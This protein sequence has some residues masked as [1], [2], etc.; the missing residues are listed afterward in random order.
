MTVFNLQA[1]AKRPR[2]T[3]F[4]KK[5]SQGRRVGGRAFGSAIDLGE[6][7][8]S[9]IERMTATRGPP[10]EIFKPVATYYNNAKNIAIPGRG[11]C[12]PR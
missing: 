11:P 12:V 2:F 6:D 7:K 3:L 4:A 1:Y 9:R 5:Q 10:D 8:F